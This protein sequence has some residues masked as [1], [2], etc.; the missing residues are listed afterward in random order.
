MNSIINFLNNAWQEIKNEQTNHFA[1]V[2]ILLFI[3]SI[4]LKLGINNLFLI[5]LIL[6]TIYNYKQWKINFNLGSILFIV[7]FFI[8]CVSYF[9]SI[10]PTRTLN[11]IPRGIAF[12]IVPLIFLVLPKI[13]KSFT[14]NIIKYYSYGMVLYAIF[15]LIKATIKFLITNNT[16]VFF[17]HELVTKD[18]NAIHVSVYMS[19]AFFYFFNAG[20]QNLFYLFSIFLTGLIIFLLSSKLIILVFI[21]LWL[22]NVF[23][24]TKTAYKLRLRNLIVFCSM[25]L[26][27]FSYGKIKDRFELEFHSNTK[28]SINHEVLEIQSQG[29]EIVSIKEAW[30]ADKFSPNHYFTGTSFRVYQARMLLELIKE[31]SKWW[32]GYGLDAS[33]IK[34][35]EKALK[36]DVFRGTQEKLGYQEFNFHNQ[37]LQLLADLGIFSLVL[38]LLILLF[39]IKNYTKNKDFLHF[40]YTILMISLFLTECFLWRQRGVVYFTIFSLLFL[41]NQISKKNIKNI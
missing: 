39:L 8:T 14:D 12:L 2:P 21:L 22:I 4:P 36:Y 9:W 19:M 33:Y 5:V 3:I 10:D 13:S 41:S 23:Y 31:E 37:Y 11:A 26:L 17:Y 30:T 34:L 24:F 7:L 6:V 40:A 28:Q 32:L 27:V 25:V 1:F 16:Q 18:V 35:E 20:K 38:V 29:I 15:Y